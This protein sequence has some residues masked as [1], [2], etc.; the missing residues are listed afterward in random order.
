M[1]RAF[2]DQGRRFLSL[3]PQATASISLKGCGNGKFCY[4]GRVF[5]LLQ[6][7]GNNPAFRERFVE[8]NFRGQ[9]ESSRVE[10]NSVGVEYC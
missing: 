7:H 9:L 6:G 3:M 8:F 10:N 2:R 1:R 4:S 5:F